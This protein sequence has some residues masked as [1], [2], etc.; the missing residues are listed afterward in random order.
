[1]LMMKKGLYRRNVTWR[2]E[3]MLN[4]DDMSPL[5]FCRTVGWASEWSQWVK[6]CLTETRLQGDTSSLSTEPCYSVWRLLFRPCAGSP[7]AFWHNLSSVTTRTVWV[8]M[9]KNVNTQTNEA[10]RKSARR[11]KLKVPSTWRY[12]LS[13]HPFSMHQLNHLWHVKRCAGK[14][15]AKLCCLKN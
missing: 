1:M 7:G 6:F 14:S 15:D 13:L 3:S 9:N 10:G 2:D 5:V 12:I 11:E 8:S 4:I